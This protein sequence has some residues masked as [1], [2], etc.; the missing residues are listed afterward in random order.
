MGWEY[1]CKMFAGKGKVSVPFMMTTI[2][3]NY[4]KINA[5][6]S[7]SG[8]GLVQKRNCLLKLL[9]KQDVQHY[10][11]LLWRRL[12]QVC[13]LEAPV[14][15]QHY[16]TPDPCT[17]HHR[18][19][20]AGIKSLRY[21]DHTAACLPTEALE[22]TAE[23]KW[24]SSVRWSRC[25]STSCCALMAFGRSAAACL[26]QA[27]SWTKRRRHQQTSEPGSKTRPTARLL[28][29]D[30]WIYDFQ[31]QIGDP[32]SGAVICLILV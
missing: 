3:D 18:N 7:R 26:R 22:P 1:S 27:E 4:R 6:H 8:I 11:V 29:S 24:P 9:R 28:K 20:Q 32:E 21:T 14:W 30:P 13:D 12:V 2:S 25:A 10:R 15:W 16:I 19:S 31:S 23:P 17:I 5:M